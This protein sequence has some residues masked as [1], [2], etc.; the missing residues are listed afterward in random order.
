MKL[1]AEEFCVSGGIPGLEESSNM[2]VGERLMA[3][4]SSFSCEESGSCEGSSDS[5]MFRFIIKLD[6]PA[7]G[8]QGY[9]VWII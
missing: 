5:L 6:Q 8:D 7:A 3:R 2:E 4:A 1:L 9:M